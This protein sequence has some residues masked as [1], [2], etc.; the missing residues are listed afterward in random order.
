MVSKIQNMVTIF[1]IVI[2]TLHYS[3]NVFFDSLLKRISR[4]KVDGYIKS[5]AKKVLAH[6]GVSCKVVGLN[7]LRI[8]PGKPYILMSNHTS[9]LDIPVIIHAFPKTIRMIAKK[10]LRRVPIWGSSLEKA[11]FI[12]IDRKNRDQAIK[13]LACAKEK[14]NDGVFIWIAPE[15]TRTRTGKMRNKLKKGGIILAIEANAQIIPIG[16]RGIYDVLPPDTSFITKGLE[17][18]VHFGEIIDTAEY[19]IKRRN[20]LVN[21]ISKRL[22]Q[23]AGEDPLAE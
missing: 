22:R 9:L 6:A 17:I 18:E 2:S 4:E 15:G 3:L 8:E 11:E 21:V 20:E 19:G 23:L 16:L 7:D 12:F 10:E 13:D 14:L 1:R 5:W